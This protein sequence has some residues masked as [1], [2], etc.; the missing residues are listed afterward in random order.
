MKI[1]LVQ[2]QKKYG[3]FELNCSMTVEP[4][5]ITGLIGRNGAGKSTAFKM[6][7][8]LVKPDEGIV[9]LGG[10]TSWKL[11]S[12]TKEQIGVVL[13]E[14]GFSGYL[15]LKDVAKIMKAS[16]TTFDEKKFLEK[17]EQQRIPKDKCLKE[18][19]TG[20]KAKLKILLALSH[21]AKLLIL[22]EPTAGLDVV[23]REEILDMLREYME[24]EDNSILISSHIA[25][26]LEGLC[27]DLYFIED[28]N[29]ILHE[30]TGV[31]L[32]EYGILKVT[33][34][35][36][37][38]MDKEYLLSEREESYGYECLTAQKAFYQENY[39]DITIEKAGIDETIMLMISDKKGN[40]VY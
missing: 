24:K 20:T 36:Y 16:Y 5:S 17:C 38:K 23:A 33:K 34:E 12:S 19:S 31:L 2:A 3:S 6:I 7:L 9:K 11:S 13:A 35:Q 8:G 29:I 39:P 1:E 26:D 4:G 28:G 15:K 22:D 30:E 14:S 32:D 37:E 40:K 21:D 10:E 27:D 18:F 25:S